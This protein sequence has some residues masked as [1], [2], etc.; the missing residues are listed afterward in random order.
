MCAK[1]HHMHL[2]ISYQSFFVTLQGR[3]VDAEERRRRAEEEA[4]LSSRLVPPL[5]KRM[6]L[7]KDLQTRKSKGIREMDGFKRMK[8]CRDAL[9]A[10][11]RRG[12]ERSYH[13]KQFHDS[14]IRATARLFWKSEPPGQFSRDHQKILQLNGW[15]H[16]AQ[17]ILVSTPRRFGKTISVSMFAAALIFS[18]P[19]VEVSIYST[20][21]RISQKLLLNIKRFL[22]LIFDEMKV[23]PFKEIRM[24]MEEIVMQGNES[25][26]DNRVVN[27]YPS[28]VGLSMPRRHRKKHN[29]S[30]KH[31]IRV[32][33][34]AAVRSSNVQAYRNKNERLTSSIRRAMKKI[35]AHANFARSDPENFI[36]LRAFA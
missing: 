33:E 1:C 17:E 21:K 25:A 27:S 4:S 20:C 9:K 2:P 11:D 18:A 34:T 23:E 3:E 13:Q 10:L 36:T 35:R 12:W 8:L 28:E 29:S 24:N 6:R 26:Q 15:D 22:Y 5:A 14:F 31:R 16:L 19:S 32:L 30:R 7:T